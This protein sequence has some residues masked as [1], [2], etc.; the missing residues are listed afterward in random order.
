M[1]SKWTPT[2][3][4]PIDGEA[5]LRNFKISNSLNFPPY[6]KSVWKDLVRRSDDKDKGIN[7]LTFSNFFKIP[8]VLC[9]R[10]FSVFDTS[11]QGYLGLP[12]FYKGMVTVFDS[13]IET[14]I[15][16]AFQFFDGNSD[17]IISP[18]DVHMI[19]QYIPLEMKSLMEYSCQDRIESQEELNEIILSFFEGLDSITL[20]E[21]KKQIELKDSTIFLFLVV[22][23][24][25]NKPFSD[26][27]LSYYANSQENI[28]NRKSSCKTDLK[29][30][31]I[32]SPIISSKFAPSFKILRTPMMK[33]EREQ[34][35]RSL[36]QMCNISDSMST[37][38]SIGVTEK[39][40]SNKSAQEIMSS[41]LQNILINSGE[42]NI[43]LM[44]PNSKF[45]SLNHIVNLKNKPEL[46]LDALSSGVDNLSDETFEGWIYKLSDG[47]IKKLWFRLQE[48]YLYCK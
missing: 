41:N 44:S 27:T 29:P 25:T 36:I 14:L 3:F 1:Q 10:L 11:K 6:I 33:N 40:S 42:K 5:L 35:R 26:Q 31:L 43:N 19:F 34:L 37:A 32:A 2:P 16:F 28:V 7:F 20:K 8:G 9:S 46:L 24:L 39:K 23:L 30:S 4:K 47:K 45:S 22:Y 18:E 21:F 13:K 17:G 38:H 15:K 12:E 48:K